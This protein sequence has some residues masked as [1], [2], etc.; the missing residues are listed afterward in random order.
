[1]WRSRANDTTQR[2][3]PMLSP[4]RGS[5]LFVGTCTL[6]YQEIRPHVVKD[7][8]TSGTSRLSHQSDLKNM[9]GFSH[10]I[11]DHSPVYTFKKPPIKQQKTYFPNPGQTAAVRISSSILLRS[12]AAARTP[13]GQ[14]ESRCWLA[15]RLRSW[16]P[17]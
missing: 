7:K 12:S 3:P 10:I 15:C 17:H 2:S 13:S 8:L 6:G 14:L 4:V 1:M 5:F 11:L 9:F 16:R